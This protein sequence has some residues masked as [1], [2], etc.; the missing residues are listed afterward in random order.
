[1]KIFFLAVLV[2]CAL[3]APQQA[4]KKA[5]P[6]KF[7]NGPI[8]WPFY[9]KG[10]DIFLNLTIGTPGLA[11]PVSNARNASDSSSFIGLGLAK[12]DQGKTIGTLSQENFQIA[13]SKFQYVPFV[14]Q[15][16]PYSF[17]N[18]IGFGP[19]TN[20]F[21][22]LRTVLTGA[23]DKT[24]VIAFDK[25]PK[26][27][28]VTLGG[29]DKKRCYKDWRYM[30]EALWVEPSDQNSPQ[31]WG[32]AIDKLSAGKWAAANPGFISF[33]VYDEEILWPKDV[34]ASLISQLGS[35]DGRNV[36]C[37]TKVN[38]D[39]KVQ[40][41]TI[42]LTPEIYLDHDMEDVTGTCMLKGATVNN[43]DEYR[44]PQAFFQSFCLSF[45]HYTK[46]VGFATKRIN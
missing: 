35:E 31:R 42:T 28:F 44:L 41:V 36:L 4:P 3:A 27:G 5:K 14:L 26:S 1:M 46:Q 8:E 39:F 37:D 34:Y 19:I 32:V 40:D 15:Y 2:V 12:N 45:N 22:F 11:I 17:T 23:L 13:N 9:A 43:S 21:T 20:D 30:D 38:I 18:Y 24:I 10:D 25:F 16:P 6:T 33:T 7:L 29:L